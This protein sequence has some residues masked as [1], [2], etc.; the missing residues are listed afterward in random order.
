MTCKATRDPHGTTFTIPEDKAVFTA[1]GKRIKPSPEVTVWW[2][3]DRRDETLIIRQEFPERDTADVL[4]LTLA[5]VYD[6]HH[7]LGCAILRS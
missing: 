7:A 3:R 2:N 4:E 6:L 1:N 5:Q